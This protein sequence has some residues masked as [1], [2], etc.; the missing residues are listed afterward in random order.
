MNSTFIDRNAMELPN[1]IGINEM[2]MGNYKISFKYYLL[3]IIFFFS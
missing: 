1:I 2:E 3:E